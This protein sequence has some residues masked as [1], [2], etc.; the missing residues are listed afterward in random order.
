MMTRATNTGTNDV[1]AY[2]QTAFPKTEPAWDPNEAEDWDN[3]H[4]YRK[5]LMA[6]LREGERK[7]I[8]MNKVLEIL[9][10]S[11]ESPA[12][13]YDRLGET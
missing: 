3:L 2:F 10:N 7:A 9:Q 5:A 12:E 8:N 6:G 4:R 13:F 1:Q 11:Y